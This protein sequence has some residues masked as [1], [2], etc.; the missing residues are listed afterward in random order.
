MRFRIQL[1]KESIP[2]NLFDKKDPA[3]G[4]TCYRRDVTH[5]D[6]KNATKEN[7]ARITRF[8]FVTRHFDAYFDQ[9]D[10]YCENLV[11]QHPQLENG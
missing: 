8:E 1:T 10:R 9:E 11:A 2:M 7:P 5:G 6:V 4:E 3:T